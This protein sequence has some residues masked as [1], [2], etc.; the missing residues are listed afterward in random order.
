MLSRTGCCAAN[1]GSSSCRVAVNLGLRDYRF[2]E[3][4]I[5]GARAVVAKRRRGGAAM[6][7]SLE[8]LCCWSLGQEPEHNNLGAVFE[9]DV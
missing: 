3:L 5:G 2:A 7:A 1:P 8:M 9:S 6:A 4:S